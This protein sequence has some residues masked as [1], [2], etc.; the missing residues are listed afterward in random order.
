MI[1]EKKSI[2]QWQEISP[3]PQQVVPVVA[4]TTLEGLGAPERC[5]QDVVV[6]K[7]AVEDLKKK[8]CGGFFWREQREHQNPPFESSDTQDKDQGFWIGEQKSPRHPITKGTAYLS[9]ATHTED[10]ECHLVGQLETAPLICQLIRMY[11]R[12][13]NKKI[14]SFATYFW[15]VFSQAL[16]CAFHQSSTL[17]RNCSIS[18][19]LLFFACKIFKIVSAEAMGSSRGHLLKG[20]WNNELLVVR[21]KAEMTFWMREVNEYCIYGPL[22]F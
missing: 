12:E 7:Q 14:I 18:A 13:I 5:Q 16:T 17:E 4:V 15:L 21:I 22:A 3:S 1:S 19:L 10:E 20:I 9:E 11:C 8:C 2:F 6:L